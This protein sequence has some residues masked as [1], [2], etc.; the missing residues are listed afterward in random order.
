MGFFG[1]GS[2]TI[3]GSLPHE[4]R[5]QALSF[6]FDQLKKIPAWPQLT[7]YPDE[8]MTE[9][10][11]F[12]LAGFTTRDGKNFIDSRNPN[13][14][15]ET[16]QFYEDFLQSSNFNQTL[17]NSRFSFNPSTGASFFPFLD[18]LFACR[19][20][21]VAVKGQI[22]GPFTLSTSLLDQ[23]QR[24]AI[25]DDRLRDMIVKGLSMNAHWQISKMKAAQ[26]PVIIFI[27]EPAMAGY[28]SSAFLGVSDEMVLEMLNEVSA[29]IH[30]AGGLAG[31]HVCANTDWGLIFKSD[32]DIIN[33]D[34]YGFFDRF[35]LY[36][37]EIREFL[38]SGKNIA[39]GIIPTMRPDDIVRET[40]DSLATF[41][42]QHVEKFKS[43]DLP[44]SQISQDLA[45]KIVMTGVALS[46]KLYSSVS[47][48]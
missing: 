48:Q 33:F 6:L 7:F 36:R 46:E 15:E 41:W 1:E 27:D 25:Y 18:Y 39:W 2:F 13:F 28:G 45:E 14:E 37:D 5:N 23:D 29:E 21:L 26:V 40:P 8:R 47:S 22:T 31:I 3:I 12:G 10:Y 38:L 42:L 35:E 43:K 11:K 9:Q 32:L 19:K 44:V 24:Y 4:N 34:A 20:N 16:L 17:L 30:K